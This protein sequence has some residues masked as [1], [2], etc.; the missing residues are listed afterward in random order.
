MRK[1]TVTLLSSALLVGGIGAG[2]AL[3]ASGHGQQTRP[4]THAASID[5]TSRVQQRERDSAAARH[6]REGLAK[7]RGHQRSD[8]SARDRELTG[9]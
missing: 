6:S 1:L 7:E 3:A 2:S 9:R 4:T 5:R 8:R